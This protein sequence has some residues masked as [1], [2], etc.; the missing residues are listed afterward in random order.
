[1]SWSEG[2]MLQVARVFAQARCLDFSG[3]TASDHLEKPE[4]PAGKDRDRSTGRAED[5]DTGEQTRHGRQRAGRP[6]RDETH[7]HE[8]GHRAERQRPNCAIPKA[9]LA[10]RVAVV[11]EKEV[12]SADRAASK[13][14][15]TLWPDPRGPPSIA[16]TGD[17]TRRV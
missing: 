4:A 17:V 6:R 3:P 10:L 1:M 16:R 7:G 9:H 5:R 13:G 11:A 8:P 12:A 14:S 2:G 15:G